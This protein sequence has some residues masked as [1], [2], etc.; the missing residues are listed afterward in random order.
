MRFLSEGTVYQ[1]KALCF[2]VSTAPQVFTKVFAA[3]SA[4]AHS[5]GIRLLRYL[6]DWLV[7][8]SS[9]A[10][11]KKNV[12]ELLSVCHSLGIVINEKSGLVPSSD[13]RL[14][15]YDHQYRGRQD[16]SVPC[17]GREI[18]VG[19]RDVLYYVRSPR[20]ALAGG[21]GSPGFAGEASSSQTTSNTLSAVAFEDTLVSRV[22]S[23]LP[24]GALVPG[25]EGGFV[26]VDGKGPSS[27]GAS[28]RDTRS[29]STP[30]LGRVSVGMGRTPPRTGSVQGVVGAGEVAAHQP[31]RN[32]GMVSGIAVISGVGC[33]SRR[34]RDMRQLDCGGLMSTSR[35]GRSPVP[36]A[37][38]PA[39]F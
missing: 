18:S 4:W 28:F 9:E 37:R 17:A 30:V 11:A 23:S 32:E 14:P 5:H 3:L 39:S 27:Q 19:G 2:A 31:S 10:K 15:R 34:D 35:A 12:Q 8:A 1:F 7:L 16:F 22:G 6:D 26:L 21:F 25:G 29:G 13:C 36:F 20:S 38:W 24:S 33:R